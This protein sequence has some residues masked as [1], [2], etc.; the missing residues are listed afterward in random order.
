M[1]IGMTIALAGC[2]RIRWTEDVRLPDGRT[3]TLTRLQNYGGPTEIGQHSSARDY[4]FEFTNPDTGE[5]V[6]WQSDR[7]L[8]TVALLIHDRAPYLLLMTAF[9]SSKVKFGC[10]DPL[11]LLYRYEGGRWLSTP[12]ADIP[13]KRLRANVTSAADKDLREGRIKH[14]PVERTQS[15]YVLNNKPW[16][17]D[18]TNVHQTFDPRN[19]NRQSDYLL[20]PPEGK[21]S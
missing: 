6:R 9:Y 10:P 16:L 15:S 3:I 20:V 7:E 19:C 1:A 5:R 18:F 21:S 4:W 17:M 12:L 13:V 2:E 11:Y 14:L 8:A